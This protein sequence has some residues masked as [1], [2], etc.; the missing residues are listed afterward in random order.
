[1]AATPTSAPDPRALL[2]L[3]AVPAGL[4]LLG[5]GLMAAQGLVVTIALG[6]LAAMVCRRGQLALEGRGMG[7]RGALLVAVLGFLAVIAAL[8]VSLF[9]SIAAVAATLADHADE[10]TTLVTDLAAQVSA[11]A[12]LPATSVP[13]VDL[14]T[15]VNAL[16]SALGM[17]TPAVTA[18]A[19]ATL[20][21]VYL[22]AD[23]PALGRRLATV[24]PRHVIVRYDQVAAE[25]TG[26]VKVRAI[27]GAGTTVANTV[28]LLVL[29]VPY[30]VLWGLVSFL[31]SFI[32]NFGFLIS[33]IPPAVFALISGSPLGAVLVIVGYTAINLAS[34]YLVQP[35]MMADELDL[36]PVA[37]ITGILAWTFLIGPAGAL[38]AVPLTLITRA[39][40]AAF[41]GARWFTALLGPLPEEPT[42]EG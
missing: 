11:A 30:A 6:A 37:V 2:P 7:A 38:L 4:V 13:Q 25:I 15:G 27:I 24:L 22:L 14:A 26:Y 8:L 18:I 19:M 39:V 5:A 12:G 41:P 3:V 28:L 40:L 34:D 17:V 35:R 33:L 29:G 16:R 23:A 21:L 10:L 1:M 20:I 9:A 42:I 32:P 36:S 31:F